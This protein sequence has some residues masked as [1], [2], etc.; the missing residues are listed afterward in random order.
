MSRCV[1]QRHRE[2]AMLKDAKDVKY[3]RPVD[4][5]YGKRN[6]VHAKFKI[7]DLE[8]KALLKDVPNTSSE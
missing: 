5:R 8:R 2:G 1:S 6:T 7:L 4:S 3:D